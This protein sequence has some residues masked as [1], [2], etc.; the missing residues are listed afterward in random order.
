MNDPIVSMYVVCTYDVCM[1]A[2]MHDSLVMYVYM[3]DVHVCI[4]A[5]MFVCIMICLYVGDVGEHQPSW[6]VIHRVGNT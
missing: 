3:N 1:F 6:Y 5:C 4:N 2:C